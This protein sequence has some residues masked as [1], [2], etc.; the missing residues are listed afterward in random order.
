MLLISGVKKKL[1]GYE[2]L[3]C[4]LALGP[5]AASG[6]GPVLVAVGQQEVRGRV[7]R[8]QGDRRNHDGVGQAACPS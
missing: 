7:P 8:S 5:E 4:Y 6:S 2:F 3:V 1:L